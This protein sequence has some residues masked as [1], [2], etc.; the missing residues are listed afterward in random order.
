[1]TLLLAILVLSTGGT[2]IRG[3]WVECEGDQSASYYVE[4]R[5]QGDMWVEKTT[6][7]RGVFVV[8]VETGPHACTI[9]KSDYIAQTISLQDKDLVVTLESVEKI[10]N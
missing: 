6:D 10:A 5:R 3:A 8:E 9:S 2:P 1:M 4:G 7:S